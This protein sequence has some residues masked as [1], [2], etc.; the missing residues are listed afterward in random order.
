MGATYKGGSP[1]YRTLRDNV[2][3]MKSDSRYHFQD[4]Y[5][6]PKHKGSHIAH[7]LFFDDP[8]SAAREFYDRITYG[9]IENEIG[10][11]NWTTKMK[12]GTYINFR[13]KTS[14]EGSP[15]VQI[16][17]K[18]SSDSAGIQYHKVHFSK[19]KK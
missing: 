13:I 10:D 4:G 2:E 9:G 11:D 15:A 18:E 7:D 19:V 6:G 12:D 5:F 16:D 17:I 1:T 14:S 8:I 3:S